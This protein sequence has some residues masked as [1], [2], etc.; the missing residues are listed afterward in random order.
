[1]NS[2]AQRIRRILSYALPRTQTTLRAA[3]AEDRVL[4]ICTALLLV[5]ALI[6]LFLTTFLPFSDLGINTASADL[7]WDAA[8]GHQPVAHFYKLAS[9]PVPYW[10]SYLFCAVVGQ[11][12]GPLVAAKVLTAV[13]L[14]LVP[15]G[16]M[17]LLLALGRDPRLGLWAFLAIW[18]HNLYAGWEGMM[19][20][21]GLTFFVL[22]WLIEAE[23]LS[24]GLRLVPYTALIGLTH[25][26]ATALLGVAGAA[27]ALTRRPLGR[28]I[29]L[30]AIA[31]SGL[32]LAVAPWLLGKVVSSGGGPPQSFSF[33]WD[34]P[35][36]KLSRLF[37]FTLDNF[38]HRDGERV[39][40]VAFVLLI[41]GPLIL[42]LLPARGVRHRFTAAVLVGA[43]GALYLF[44]PFAVGG[45][46]SHWYTYPRFASVVLV[47]LLL[48]PTP[49]LRGWPALALVP[50]VLVALALDVKVAEQFH[51][52][53]LQ[54]RPFLE[55]IKQVPKGAS[56][57]PFTFDDGDSDPYL[58]LPPYHQFYAYI[59]ALTHG[60]SPYLWDNTSM[61]LNFRLENKPPA[62]GWDGKF[63]LDEHGSHY[64][65]LLVQGF[66]HQDPVAGATSSLGLHPTLVIQ[67]AR[68]RLYRVR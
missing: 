61:P 19:L 21:V 29:A 68:W 58:R 3:F 34:S 48:I 53:A 59:T 33:D 40:A 62:P 5:A 22:A 12:F 45:P 25:V 30:H 51:A 8:R 4:L 43:A 35:A 16:T 66:E 11:V 36:Q 7:L 9:G 38:S 13:I 47:W 26:H 2:S 24:D 65:Y 63:S 31:L 67:T 56:V 10:T 55:V 64:D 37:E 15:L 28:R 23:T 50:G 32:L 44:L 49:R 1:M 60:Y 42:G 17:R 46:I 52:F 20:G 18:E 6:P 54:T 14:A 57:L 27:L 41:L 39:A